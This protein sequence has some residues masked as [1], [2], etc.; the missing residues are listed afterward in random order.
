MPDVTVSEYAKMRGVT[1]QAV[2]QAIHK[3]HL[4]A[5]I[6]SR[7]PRVLIDPWRADQEWAAN[8][9][10]RV[11]DRPGARAGASSPPAAVA[12]DG[13]AVANY[14]FERARKAKLDADMAELN[15]QK[16]RGELVDLASARALWFR[17]WRTFRDRLFAIAEREAGTLSATADPAECRTIVDRAIRQALDD[18]PP[19][20][21][22]EGAS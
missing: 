11:I 8:V 19:A 12:G 13:E 5:S 2:E 7:E 18:L 17:H 4:Q 10:T 21:P 9:R 6:V 15:L 16:A 3:K 20:P 1:R 22:E 14:N